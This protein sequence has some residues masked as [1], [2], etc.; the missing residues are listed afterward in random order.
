MLSAQPTSWPKTDG[1]HDY[2]CLLMTIRRSE[3]IIFCPSQKLARLQRAH[4]YLASGSPL[5]LC[6]HVSTCLFSLRLHWTLRRVVT[7]LVSSSKHQLMLFIYKY[8]RAMIISHNE[9][10]VD[11]SNILALKQQLLIASLKAENED[12]ID[13]LKLRVAQ[14]E[15]QKVA[16]SDE[17]KE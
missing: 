17:V 11:F 12:E 6:L 16:E 10:M 13:Q 1:Y 4:S 5:I 15:L 2:L 3:L 14:L 8:R 9:D 7:L